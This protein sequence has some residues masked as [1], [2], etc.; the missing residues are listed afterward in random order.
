MAKE[1]EQEVSVRTGY[2]KIK[3]LKEK[4]LEDEAEKEEEAIDCPSFLSR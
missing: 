1:E 4:A 3:E 2:K